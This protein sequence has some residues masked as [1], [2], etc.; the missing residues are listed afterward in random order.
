MANIKN[1]NNS[2][3]INV[4]A[5]TK[6]AQNLQKIKKNIKNEPKSVKN[7]EKIESFD[8]FPL[9]GE[10]F[11]ENE[12]DLCDIIYANLIVLFSVFLSAF[13]PIVSLALPFL[14]IVYFEVG[15][16]GF[17]YKSESGERYHFEDLFISIKKFIKVFCI[18]VI[19]MFLILF[20]TCI[21]IVPGVLTML[22]YSFTP[23]I[24][25][26][27]DDLDAKGVLALSKE[28]TK[29][30]RWNIFFYELLALASVCVAM[31]LMFLFILFF[32]VFFFVPAYFYILFVVL[33]GV[34]DFVLVALPIVEIAIV[35]NFIKSK[36]EKVTKLI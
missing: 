29:G 35:D 32:D 25:F 5:K 6:N 14:F 34:L 22:N 21:F 12:R 9:E 7:D 30:Y 27:S 17:I 11:L 18:Y 23:L 2:S 15:L 1:K 20:W 31:T 33:A 19:K 4:E 28:M 3:K 36:Q 26:E 10:K 16:F 13:I 24:I 8:T